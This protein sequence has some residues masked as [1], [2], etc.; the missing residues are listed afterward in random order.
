MS[1]VH[2]FNVTAQLPKALEPLEELANDLS[3]SWIP[4]ARSL[5]R[6]ISPT[7]WNETNGNPVAVLNRVSSKRLAE[8]ARD[9]SFRAHLAEVA[10]Q[11]RDERAASCWYGEQPA[12]DRPEQD[13]LVG[14]FSAEYGIEY[15]LVKYNWPH[16]LNKPSERQR[17]IWAYKILFLDVLF[18]LDVK[19]IIFVDADQIVRA[20]LRE[21]TELDLG[22]APYGYTP[23]CDSREDMDGFR[24]WKSGYWA[25][26]LQVQPVTP[27]PLLLLFYYH[28]L[29]KLM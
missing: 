29:V 11:V 19:K 8:L 1:R 28:I 26:H 27:R 5:F 17:L 13:M 10:S 7:L 15:Q 18:P 6:R 25:G 24:F 12:T 16:W 20:D 4:A 22:G 14:Y 3:F 9:R 21:L 23:F 2:T